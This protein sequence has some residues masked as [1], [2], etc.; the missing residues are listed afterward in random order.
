[1]LFLF[2]VYVLVWLKSFHLPS[3]SLPSRD[4]LRGIKDLF[5]LKIFF[6]HECFFLPMCKQAAAEAEKSDSWSVGC[7]YQ[8]VTSLLSSDWGQTFAEKWA[9]LPR[10]KAKKW[11]PLAEQ[12]PQHKLKHSP[13][14]PEKKREEKPAQS[15]G[16]W[17]NMLVRIMLNSKCAISGAVESRRSFWGF[18][19]TQM[20]PHFCRTGKI[21]LQKSLWNSWVR[22]QLDIIVFRR[23]A[24]W[25]QPS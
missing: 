16:I 15:N 17:T 22:K 8:P 3:K 18:K 20:R 12:R 10:S 14:K 2:R 7:L 19:M 9:V 1:M 6:F 13:R 11:S 25:G 5:L 23:L 24:P 4:I 21:T